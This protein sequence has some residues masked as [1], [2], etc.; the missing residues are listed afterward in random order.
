MGVQARIV[1]YAPD[2]TAAETAARAAFDRIAILDEIMSDYRVDSELTELTRRAGMGPIPVSDDLFRVLDIA[3]RLARQS[4][5]AFD[6]TVGPYVRLW[7]QARRAGKL[8]PPDSLKA[9]ERLVGWRKLRLD[10]CARTVAL[11]ER[12]MKLDLGGIAKGYAADEAIET[13]RRNGIRSALI[14]FGGDVVVSESPPDEEGWKITAVLAEGREVTLS[15]AAISTSGDTEQFVEIGGK[16]YSHVVDP[17]TGMGVT[18]RVA[19]S[20]IAPSGVLSDALATTMSVAGPNG[21]AM[22]E[23]EYPGVTAYVRFLSK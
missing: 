1:L 6:I 8:P 21:L 20:V 19:I 14:E 12:G 5:G 18:D 9:A 15:N 3:Q 4:N 22:V 7:R 17:R 23:T 16:R 2:S 11:E 13:L 10:Q